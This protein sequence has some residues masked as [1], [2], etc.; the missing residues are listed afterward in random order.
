MSQK[1]PSPFSL[2]LETDIFNFGSLY[3]QNAL[4][5]GHPALEGALWRISQ[6]LCLWV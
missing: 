4:I 3:V 6:L 5:S 2:S 1:Q